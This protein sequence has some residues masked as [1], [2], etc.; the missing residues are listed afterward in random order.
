MKIDPGSWPA[1]SR[2]LDE[3][4]DLPAPSRA[5]WLESLGPEHAPVLPLLRQMIER[6][7]SETE[8]F[9]D[10]LPKLQ[11]AVDGAAAGAHIGPYR[12]LRQLGQ[13]GMGIV[14]LAERA[15]SDLKRPV[16]LKAPIVSF[17]D[18]ALAG[19]FVRERDILAQLTHPNIARLYDAGVTE[20]GQPYLAMEYVEG[21]RI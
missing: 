2:L 4:L 7:A 5:A 19:R 11:A 1:L 3:C 17:Q 6:R 9:L 20:Q 10:T 8:N 16:A 13:G 12:L 21:D 15:N 14:W 18:P